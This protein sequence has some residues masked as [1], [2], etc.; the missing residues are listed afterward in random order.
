LELVDFKFFTLITDPNTR[1]AAATVLAQMLGALDLLIFDKD[2]EIN[3]FLPTQGFPQ[4]LPS[5]GSWHKFLAECEKSKFYSARLKY[6]E[7]DEK[8]FFGALVESNL[9]FVFVR[10]STDLKRPLQDLKY[11]CESFALVLKQERQ[12]IKHRGQNQV[13]EELSRDLKIFA[14]TLDRR[15]KELSQALQESEARGRALEKNQKELQKAKN[16]AESAA[17]AKTN[18]LANMS[19]EIRTP[20]GVIIGFSQILKDPLTRDES[21][22]YLET[23]IRN[24]QLLEQIINDILDLSKIEAGRME[25][26]PLPVNISEIG[27]L[28]IESFRAKAELKGLNLIFKDLVGLK[29]LVKSD[30]RALRQ[31]LINLIG[32]GI[33]FTEKGSVTLSL[34]PGKNSNELIF[35]IEDTGVGIETE[36]ISM[37]FQPF[38]QADSSTSR[39]Y[40]GTGL[41]LALSK[42]LA[43]ALGGDVRIESSKPFAGTRIE[44]SIPLDLYREAGE[45]KPGRR[46]KDLETILDLSKKTI[47]IVDDSEDNQKLVQVILKKYNANLHAARNGVEAVEAASKRKFDLILMDVQMPVLDGL[48]ATKEIRRRGITTPIIALTAHALPEDRDKCIAVG[49]NDYVSKPINSLTLKK[50]IIGNIIN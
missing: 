31:I 7:D 48:S 2:E 47:L 21:G 30:P 44:F 33:K 3:C 9:I 50:A 20:L 25:I 17:E 43:L 26:E 13:L 32:N 28:I 15:T 41:G 1:R 6:Y 11:F 42:R 40:G 27:E 46:A 16:S 12:S 22:K 8:T 24:A 5:G 35:A 37:L 29:H 38:Q 18:F 14:D 49:C 45:R 36:K 23:I 34:E 39:K 19:H 10:P 4:T